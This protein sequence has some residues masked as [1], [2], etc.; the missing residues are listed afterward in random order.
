[1]EKNE[2]MLVFLSE[3][4]TKIYIYYLKSQTIQTIKIKDKIKASNFSLIKVGD[5]IYCIGGTTLFGFTDMNI[6][7]SIKNQANI[8]T[9]YSLPSPMVGM[10]LV[11]LNN[12][13]IYAIGGYNKNYSSECLKFDINNN[14][15]RK[16]KN[17]PVTRT[18]MSA[19]LLNSR[20]ICAFGG[21]TKEHLHYKNAVFFYD[22][23]DEENE[24]TFQKFYNQNEGISFD[25]FQPSIQI[26][27]KEIIILGNNNFNFSNNSYMLDVVNSST[28]IINQNFT[29]KNDIAELYKGDIYAINFENKFLMKYSHFY[30][31]WKQLKKSIEFS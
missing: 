11:S 7:I 28:F 27:P 15:W 8:I 9:N 29:M 5:F 23:T 6:C 21:Y 24:W 20:I 4:Y 14:I 17:L 1:M 19:C 18:A 25:M 10:A 12:N 22:T 13:F 31:K 26:S 30:K 2:N 16:I 3:K